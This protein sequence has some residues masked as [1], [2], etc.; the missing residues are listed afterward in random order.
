MRSVN[1]VWIPGF[2]FDNALSM[3]RTTTSQYVG[4][5]ETAFGERRDSHHPAQIS[6]GVEG[7]ALR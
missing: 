6:P 3:P 7:R 4:G 5:I 2:T 1:E